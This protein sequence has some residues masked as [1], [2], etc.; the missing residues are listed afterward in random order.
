MYDVEEVGFKFH[1]NS[2]MAAIGLVQLK[3][4][5]Q[6]NSY[7]RQ[8][9]QWYRQNFAGH[10]HIRVV[11]VAKGCESSTHLLQIRV[12]N[13]DQVMLAL[14]EH[15]VYPGV[16]YQDNTEYQMYSYAKGSCPQAAKA[17]REIISLP[18]HLGLTKSDVDHVSNLVIR[19]AE[20][21]NSTSKGI[22]K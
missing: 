1:G 5:D 6:D 8:L 10:K 13:R 18:M 4:L 7:R 16:H 21:N 12:S 2:I 17:A 14:N 9:A 22:K 19:Y 20:K 15:E 11:D 3:Y